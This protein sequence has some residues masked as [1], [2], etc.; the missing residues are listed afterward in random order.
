M[1]K[2]TSI[3][4]ITAWDYIQ[5]HRSS[6]L[7]NSVVN[8]A[9]SCL[10]YLSMDAFYTGSYKL[11]ERMRLYPFL[12]YAAQFWVDHFRDGNNE[13]SVE[14]MALKLLSDKAK[15]ASAYEALAFSHRWVDGYFRWPPSLESGI[16]LAAYFGLSNIIEHFQRIGEDL[17]IRDAYGQTPLSWAVDRQHLKAT[18]ILMEV[19]SSMKPSNLINHGTPLMWAIE[20]QNREMVK[21]LVVYDD[22]LESRDTEGRTPL[23]LAAAKPDDSIV[24]LLVE[25]GAETD[26]QDNIGRTPLF[27]AAASGQVKNFK[28]LFEKSSASADMQDSAGRTPLS[29]AAG[30][31]HAA[32]VHLLLENDNVVPDS[33]DHS[34]RTPLSWAA[35]NGSVEVVR[36]LIAA[37]DVDPNSKD[38]SGL[39]PVLWAAAVRSYEAYSLLAPFWSVK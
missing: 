29:L 10:S 14:I 31:G 37:N 15:V 2:L 32:V 23:S 12:S 26:L 4:D 36:L 1:V 25:A 9:A 8:I 13:H 18:R 24:Q 30:A 20:Q 7:H 34:S 38:E 39:T 35:E 3:L 6:L 16:H 27:W 17:Q 28:L 19:R 5:A 22:Q 33:R 11:E 21:L